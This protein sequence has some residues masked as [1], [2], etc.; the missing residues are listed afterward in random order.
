MIHLAAEVGGI[1]ANRANPAA[2]VRDNLVMGTHVLERPAARQR[3]DRH[4]RHHLRLP[5]VH[6][7]AVPRGRPLERLPRGDERPLRPREEGR[8]SCSAQ[9][10]REQYGLNVVYLSR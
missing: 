4:R 7:R 10:Y 2:S 5:E 6:A 1:G 9:A 8:S 3:Q